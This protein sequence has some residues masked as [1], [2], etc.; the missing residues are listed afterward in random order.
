VWSAFVV[1]SRRRRTSLSP[2]ARLCPGS[3]GRAPR[4]A[5]RLPADDRGGAV[6]AAIA[7]VQGRGCR[8]GRGTWSR[9]GRVTYDVGCRA[10]R[11][12]TA[13]DAF[14]E[15]E[16][17][18]LGREAPRPLPAVLAPAHNPGAPV[19][20]HAHR[21]APRLRCSHR[22][23]HVVSNVF[24]RSQRR[25]RHQHPEREKPRVCRAFQCAQGDSNSHPA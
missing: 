23:S 9:T 1:L 2:T 12:R 20:V 8:P 5:I 18:D 7:A 19:A 16:R 14:L 4:N 24:P 6:L 15:G 11:R 25:G 10:A 17:L 22:C 3:R 13:G 21:L